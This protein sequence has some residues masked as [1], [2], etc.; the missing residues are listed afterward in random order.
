MQEFISNYAEMHDYGMEIPGFSNNSSHNF[1]ITP[2]QFRDIFL[3]RL[4]VAIDVIARP[5]ICNASIH[6]LQSFPSLANLAVA[7]IESAMAILGAAEH[8]STRPSSII[9]AGCHQDLTTRI[10]HMD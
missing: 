6:V 4:N 3:N 2:T 10:Y 7:D 1:L 9:D 8:F 5:R